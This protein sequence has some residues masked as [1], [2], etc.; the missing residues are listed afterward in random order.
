MDLDR[1]HRPR[2]AAGGALDL[3]A[4]AEADEIAGRA[5]M[6][7]GHSCCLRAAERFLNIAKMDWSDTRARRRR[8]GD[9]AVP[10]AGSFV[11][12]TSAQGSDRRCICCCALLA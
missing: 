9:R 8:H 7:V 12:G 1:V 10:N 4:A 6:L 2:R 5:D 3:E 11:I